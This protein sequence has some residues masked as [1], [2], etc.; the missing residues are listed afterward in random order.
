MAPQS[1]KWLN[2]PIMTDEAAGQ[3]LR[4][5]RLVCEDVIQ[6]GGAMWHPQGLAAVR[7]A[8]AFALV[9][10]GW[11][12]V[13]KVTF[14]RGKGGAE[15]PPL[16][17]L[18]PKVADFCSKALAQGAQAR[19]WASECRPGPSAGVALQA[20]SYRFRLSMQSVQERES[21]VRVKRL[22]GRSLLS[23]SPRPGFHRCHLKEGPRERSGEA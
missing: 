13:A 6:S 9:Q 22:A 15:A 5:M 18:P 1:D 12:P 4:R 16:Y 17:F 21:I 23:F 14:A 2:L 19:V 3:Q 11:Q 7:A 8:R 20:V 10:C